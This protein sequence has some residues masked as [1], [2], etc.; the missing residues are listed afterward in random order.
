MAAKGGGQGSDEIYDRLAPP[1]RGRPLFRL[2]DADARQ[3]DADA[4]LVGI[5]GWLA[6]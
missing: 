5:V 4:G 1:V 6:R 2:A 3:I